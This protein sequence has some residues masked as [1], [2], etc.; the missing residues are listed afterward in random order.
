MTVDW[1]Q[2]SLTDDAAN[3]ALLAKYRDIVAMEIARAK[4]SNWQR[5]TDAIYGRRV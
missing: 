3:A 2:W 5:V 4:A 1:T